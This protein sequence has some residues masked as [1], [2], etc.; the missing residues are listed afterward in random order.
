MDL[1]YP[2]LASACDDVRRLR[3]SDYELAGSW[4][5]A[6]ILDHLNM[7]MQMTID[8]AGFA[9]PAPLRPLF[10]LMLLPMMRKGKRE[11]WLLMQKWHAA[12]H[13]S[14]VVPKITAQWQ[15]RSI[16]RVG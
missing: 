3:E 13:L 9:F 2:D 8:D 11:Q 12:H 14:Y 5:L 16:H 15:E 10:K 4:S 6:Q 7:S 1:R